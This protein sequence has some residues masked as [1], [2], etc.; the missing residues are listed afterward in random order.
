MLGTLPNPWARQRNVYLQPVH[1]FPGMAKWDSNEVSWLPLEL[2]CA[3]KFRV[4]GHQ[5]LK[6][7]T[8][9]PGWEAGSA[10]CPFDG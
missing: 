6:R 5:P 7:R 2:V 9:R 3:G 4:H 10:R 8:N 1:Q